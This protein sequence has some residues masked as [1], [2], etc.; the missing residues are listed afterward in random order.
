MNMKKL[1]KEQ[2]NETYPSPEK[3]IDAL[4]EEVLE[5][6]TNITEVIEFEKDYDR[7]IEKLK[8]QL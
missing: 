7:F 3:N 4:V 1:V 6:I 2:L 8:K 5:Y